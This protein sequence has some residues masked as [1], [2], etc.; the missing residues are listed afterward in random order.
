MKSQIDGS[1][2]RSC[3]IVPRRSCGSEDPGHQTPSQGFKILIRIQGYIQ[4]YDV[5]Q[6]G[7]YVISELTQCSGSL[8]RLASDLGQARQK[9]VCTIPFQAAYIMKCILRQSWARDPE[10]SKS[11]IMV[12]ARAP[13]RW[14]AQSGHRQRPHQ[15]DDVELDG[16]NKA[17]AARQVN[18]AAS[19]PASQRQVCLFQD[20]LFLQEQPF[21]Q[22]VSKNFIENEK[23]DR[24]K[25]LTKIKFHFIGHLCTSLE[26]CL[27]RMF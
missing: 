7:T 5:A 21:R 6:Y 12:R 1:C 15:L 24:E 3:V 8:T 10:D 18:Q 22:G 23:W 11:K 27:Q 4:E 25:N 2:V 16:S 19:Q 26:T 9:Y 20:C 17:E 14:G 13:S